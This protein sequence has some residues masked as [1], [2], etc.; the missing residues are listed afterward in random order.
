MRAERIL[1][2]GGTGEARGLAQALIDEGFSV[3]T[4]LAGVTTSPHLP[5]GEVRRGG[6]GGEAGLVEYIG[7]DSIR[8]VVDA[9]HPYAAQISRH[10]HEAAQTAKVPY[11][12]LERPPWRAE[13]GDRWI[14]V[15]SIA[16][17]VAAL[18]SGARPFVT[19]GRKEISRFFARTDLAGVARMIEDP[20]VSPPPG[21][22]IVQARPPF[23][24]QAEIKLLQAHHITHLV[25]KNSG[26]E[27]TRTKLLA[28]REG[29]IP[30]VIIAR[31][32]KPSA[33]SH[34][35]VEAL[36]PALRQMLS[37]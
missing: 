34:S 20:D 16:D 30:V 10:A 12:R 22:T 25:T 2:L 35:T 14:E 3:V 13:T 23:D 4:S 1:I 21:W 5:A 7:H 9:T 27:L 37:P 6:F 26:G 28:A 29:K 19:I 32:P 11:L 36:L 17:A 15:A 18:P 8:A 33:P 31:P 24:I